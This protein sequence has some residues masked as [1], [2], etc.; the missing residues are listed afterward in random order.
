MAAALGD[1][2]VWVVIHSECDYCLF[3]ELQQSDCSSLYVV[4]WQLSDSA[5]LTVSHLEGLEQFHKAGTVGAACSHL[6]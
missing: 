3:V 5:G 1:A 6:I 4:F 2:T